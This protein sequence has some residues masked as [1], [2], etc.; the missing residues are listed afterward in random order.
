MFND[1]FLIV[2][3]FLIPFN[4]AFGKQALENSAMHKLEIFLDAI[5]LFDIILN[6]I[7]D[8]YSEPG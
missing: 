1:A 2:S 4:I 6:F 3:F 7:T 5:F 8:D